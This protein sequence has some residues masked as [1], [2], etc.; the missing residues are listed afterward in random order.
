MSPLNSL[1]CV[2]RLKKKAQSAREMSAVL[3]LVFSLLK[4]EFPKVP[5]ESQ[6]ETCGDEDADESL[7]R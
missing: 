5:R 1:N 4:T 6:A 2:V 3:K 7:V